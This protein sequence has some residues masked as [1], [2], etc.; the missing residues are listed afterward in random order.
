MASRT[1]S[2]ASAIKNVYPTATIFG[3]VNYGWYGFMTLQGAT[4]QNNRNFLDFYLDSLKE[5]EK[6]AG[7]RLVDVMDVHWYPEATGDN[8]RITSDGDTQGLSTARIQAPRSLWDPT[9]VENSWIAGSLGNQAISLLPLLS[10]KIRSH[11]PGT[12][13][14][15]TEYNYGGS[16]AISGAIAQADVLGQF[17]RNGVYAAAN[18]GLYSGAKAQLAGFKSFINFDRAGAKFG[19]QG[20]FVTGETAAE[21]SVYAAASSTIANMF[22]VVVI[23]KTVG[24]TPFKIQLS[25]Y[26][27]RSAKTYTIVDGQYDSPIFGNPNPVADTFKFDAPPLSVTTIAVT[28]Y[29]RKTGFFGTGGIIGPGN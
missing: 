10:G 24:T 3:P 26:T 13:L 15:I 9:Y 12:K 7:M 6:G 19:D 21:N 29:M 22:T 4:D 18:W 1:I 28:A 16:N 14:S 17:G 2:Y 25:G 11:Y 8:T 20:I 27:I 23:N 5:A